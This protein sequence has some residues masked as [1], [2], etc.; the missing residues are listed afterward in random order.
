[1]GGYRRAGN[2]VVVG[3]P[4]DLIRRRPDVRAAERRVAVQSAQIGVAVT[5]LLPAFSITGTLN[6]QANRYSQLFSSGSNA[7]VIGPGFNW[8][9]FN[10]GRIVSNID[11]QDARFQQ[12]AVEYQQTVL[13]ANEE[14]ENAIVSFL[15]SQEQAESLQFSVE[16]SERSV[17]IVLVQYREGQVDFN[18]VFNLQSALV[19][20]QDQLAEAQ[21]DVATSLVR[22]HK[23]LGGGWQL[24]LGLG[25]GPAGGAAEELVPVEPTD[26]FPPP[27]PVEDAAVMRMPAAMMQPP[28][29]M[30]PS[31]EVPQVAGPIRQEVGP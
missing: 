4:A 12:L 8:N 15:R 26:D 23:A 24:R 6:W 14:A 2:E 1:M 27:P 28:G 13:S 10:Y 16:A 21:A 22:I 20:Q 18:R 5:D 30:T 29:A 25:G 17:E 19:Q 7:G 3:I 31:F 9:I 11:V